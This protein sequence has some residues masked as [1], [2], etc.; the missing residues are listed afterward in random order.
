M[1]S[2]IIELNCFTTTKHSIVKDNVISQ[3]SII[4][5]NNNKFYLKKKKKTALHNTALHKLLNN[6]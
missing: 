3:K 1:E 2:N 5:N 4:I 6:L